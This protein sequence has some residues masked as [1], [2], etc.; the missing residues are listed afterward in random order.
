M[1]FAPHLALRTAHRAR[2]VTVA[3]MDLYI[4]LGVTRTAT[5]NDIKRAYRRLARKY[6]PDI[7]PGDRAAEQQ[8]RQ[9]AEAYETLSDPERRQVYDT[10][11]PATAPVDV[12]TFGFEG[13]DFTVSVNGAAAPTFGDLFADVFQPRSTPRPDS[14]RGADIHQEVTLTLD[15]VMH[16]TTREISVT[17]HVACRTC[18]GRGRLAVDEARCHRCQ[19]TGSLRSARGHMVFSKPCGHCGGSGRYTDIVCPSCAGRQVEPRV[20]AVTIR[21]PPGLRDGERMRIA[22]AG[23]AG[24]NGGPAGDVYVTVRIDA[25]A[26]FARDGDDLQ[27]VVPIAVHEAALGA[28]IE[29]PSFDGRARVRVPAGTQ[30]G[31]RF[32]LAERGVPSARTGRRGDLVVEVR[33][34]LP[35]DLDERS[36]ELLREF[37]ERNAGDDVRRQWPPL[38]RGA[39]G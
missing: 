20:D 30:S 10:A 28:K 14:E 36:K 37:G 19:G 21:V 38:R 22:E 6:H 12:S 26:V 31:Q 2:S 35:A 4:L 23:H 13:F 25:H 1:H 9:I 15:D 24:P 33:L 8:F 29:V 5:L 27:L 17:R 16:G 11:G 34:A 7:N 3:G 18:R 39:G 32:R